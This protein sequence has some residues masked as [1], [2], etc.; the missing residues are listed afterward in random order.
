LAVTIPEPRP[1]PGLSTISKFMT[2]LVSLVLFVVIVEGIELIKPSLGWPYY[3]L[4]APLILAPYWLVVPIWQRRHYGAERVA[5]ERVLERNR[6]LR[7]DRWIFRYL[8]PVAALVIMI[9]VLTQIGPAW[10]AAHGG[11]VTGTFTVT[12]DVCASGDRDCT[13]Y[14][15]FRSTDGSDVRTHIKDN[16]HVP[17]KLPAGA[18]IPA[19]D[20][21][22]YNGV[23][24][25]NGSTD[26]RWEG[27]FLAGLSL[28]LVGYLIWMGRLLLKRRSYLAEPVHIP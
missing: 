8:L 14:G 22:D 26:W 27:A 16:D 3:R 24:A 7:Y 1:R 28:Y 19:R 2:V 11:G 23:F 21:G 6:K 5:R 17:A 15:T 13:R 12:S 25:A 10:S 4:W 9:I 20:T 18:S